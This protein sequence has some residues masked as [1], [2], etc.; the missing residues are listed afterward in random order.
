MLEAQCF[1]CDQAHIRGIVASMDEL[2]RYLKGLA[3]EAKR[4][5]PRSTQR[6]RA[7]NRLLEAIRQSGKLFC[8]GRYDFPPEVYHDALQKTFEYI[9]KKVVD[10]YDP[11]LAQMM[12]WVNKKLNFAFKDEI[13]NFKKERERKSREISSS[14]PL[15]QDNKSTLEDILT[16]ESAPFVS[17]QL[18][19]ILEEDPE[20]LFKAQHM[21]GRPDVNFQTVALYRLDNKNLRKLAENLGVNEQALYSFFNRS[22]KKLRPHIDRYLK[23]N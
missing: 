6:R 9:S 19:Q 2:D 7:V 23:D 10:D 22:L 11:T 20:G 1:R 12:T 14:N 8:D 15:S 5:P 3:A 21:R 18:R 16:S 13:K 17:D 4:H